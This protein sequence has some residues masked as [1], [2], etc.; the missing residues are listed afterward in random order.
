MLTKSQL[1]KIQDAI[2]KR[3]L[4]ISYEAVGEHALTEA[5]LNELKRMGLI[6]G[7]VRHLLDEGATIGKVVALLPGT[8]ARDL[9]FEA[10]MELAKRGDFTPHTE[11]QKRAAEYASE[12]AGQYI[13]G[14]GDDLVKETGAISARA[15]MTA[16]RKVQ[17]KVSEAVMN[18]KTRSQLKTMLF[19]TIDNKYRDWLRVAHT[20]MNNAIQNGI[21]DELKAV[22]GEGDRQ[23]VFKRPNPD[24]CKHCKRLYLMPDG[25][26]PRVFHLS[27]LA[28]SNV[29]LKA[30]N[31][32]ATVGSVHTWCQ[33][34]LHPVLDGFDF[35]KRRVVVEP[36]GSRKKGQI[37]TEEDYNRLSD[38]SKAKTGWDAVLVDKGR[39]AEPD[40]IGKSLINQALSEEGDDICCEY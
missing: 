33:C 19:D 40:P 14:I 20:E 4:R 17:E 34:Q 10:I 21:H 28:D 31:W 37:I 15:G 23:L 18:R 39:T 25:V 13:K 26:T 35:E 12:H 1:S 38:A 11:I 24:A 29:G 9:T 5:E 32:K 7:S 22:S 6:R 16:M 8:E 3:F 2:R 30:A 27:D 36:F